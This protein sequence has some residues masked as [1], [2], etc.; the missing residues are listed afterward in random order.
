MLRTEQLQ[1]ATNPGLR[2][3]G[4]SRLCL[5]RSPFGHFAACCRPGRSSIRSGRHYASG[6]AF[7][8]PTSRSGISLL[9][10]VIHTRH[11]FLQHR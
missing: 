2:P 6:R 8:I 7:Y 1:H 3:L 9:V 5:R 11:P 4:R 10:L